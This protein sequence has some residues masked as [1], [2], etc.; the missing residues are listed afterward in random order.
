VGH[1][2]LAAEKPWSYDAGVLRRETRPADPEPAERMAAAA[3]V[4]VC[5]LGA[6]AVWVNGE[7]MQLR[8]RE[9][10]VVAALVLHGRGH[11][12]ADRLA[13]LVWT[14]PPPTARKSLQ[15]HI[16]RIRQRVGLELIETTAQ[17]Y[18]LAPW[19]STDVGGL[20]S[21]QGQALG[22][23][24][25]AERA[26]RLEAIL[27]SWRGE[28]Y[29]EL[30]LSD[31]V[32]AARAELH[33]VRAQIEEEL[34]AATLEGGDLQRGVALLK[35]LVVDEPFRERR[36]WLYMVGLYRADQRRD[37]LLA[38]SD[39]QA[40]LAERVGLDAGHELRVLEARIL[41][42]DPR[43]DDLPLGAGGTALRGAFVG[44]AA[45]QL[46]HR[47]VGRSEDLRQ[48]DAV[49]SD[50]V[51]SGGLRM[52]V[53]EADAGEG[54]TRLALEVARTIHERGG[55]I[56]WGRCSAD[57]GLP[58][59][60]VVEALG[61]VVDAD[62]GLLDRLGPQTEALAAILPEVRRH[63][64]IPLLSTGPGSDARS[65]LFRA[66]GAAF[67]DLTQAPLLW[68]VDDLQ[69]AAGDTLALLDHTFRA[70]SERPVL[71]LVTT[72]QAVGPIAGA[73]GRWQR[74]L[75]ATTIRL[76]GLGVADVAELLG[77]RASPASESADAIG[78][79]ATAMA[80]H[81]RT[82]GNAFYVVSLLSA[83]ELDGD[84]FFDPDQVPET[85]RSWIRRRRD[86]LPASVAELLGLGAVVGIE[87]DIDAQLLADC[88][89]AGM[90]D[91]IDGYERLLREGFFEEPAASVLRFP[92]ALVRDAVY[93]SLSGFRRAWF[94]RRV[95][96]ALEARG[97][98]SPV[99][100]AYH[101]SR[102]GPASDAA[103]YRHAMAATELALDQG[104][105]ASASEHGQLTRARAQAPG[106]QARALVGV[107]R[108]QRAQGLVVEAR[109]S[110]QTAIDLAAA[111]GVARPFAEGVLAL[112][113][114]GGGGRGVAVELDDVERIDLLRRA[115]AGLDDADADL[116]VAVLSE[117]AW[118]LLLTDRAGER[119]ALAERAIEVARRTTGTSHLAAALNSR[120]LVR[121]GPT[122]LALRLADI[123]EILRL[124]ETARPTEA[125]LAALVARH[126]DLLTLGDRTGAREALSA[127][128]DLAEAYGHP[129]WSWVV[130]SWRALDAVID[131]NLER[132]EALAFAALEWQ[133]DFPRAQACL[134]VNLVDLRLYQ[135][136]AVEV[137]D[138]LE[139]AVRE[140]PHIPTYRA[141]LTLC[142]WESGDIERATAEYRWFADENFTNIPDD[143]N[144]LLAL[145]VLGSVAARLGT[146]EQ[147][148]ALSELLSPWADQHVVLNCYDGGGAYWGP[149]AH[150]LA[151]LSPVG[152]ERDRLFEQAEVA[153]REFGAPLAV[154]RI[155]EDRRTI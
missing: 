135:G 71:V 110:L 5:V 19:V 64:T 12:D 72:R 92:H 91:F 119:V 113:G 114:G 38:F 75:R 58:Y 15:N 25:A 54:K 89:G 93:D 28:A 56:V 145:G 83:G 73:L 107:G 138:L 144:R 77:D 34:A 70:V 97:S 16:V 120:R 103:T 22:V 29:V 14:D 41:N 21:A 134:G 80:L 27:E 136:R 102:A 100:L 47:F 148:R 153:A 123:D 46:E 154:Q 57:A 6:C 149:V 90:G 69:W 111:E 13:E 131:G 84:G 59:E 98:E 68:V 140:N 116:L 45:D 32:D 94:H 95:A 127:C 124:P 63:A 125:T 118:S 133:P 39:A 76:R 122:N 11:L 86:E 147:R 99:L 106:E 151:V 4:R 78:T 53:V 37:S 87:V 10:G 129:F 143:T 3:E 104:A 108:A 137:V 121:S 24:G 23:L 152:T 40:A 52:V 126:E 155:L 60:P 9:R 51:A 8:P 30:P 117:L 20:A 44:P 112:V 150:I 36:W 139:A 65:L 67:S 17:G 115:L 49:W 33:E 101:F 7:A 74:W 50:V 142:C 82:G 43:L 146:T 1:G 2:A 88:S 132:A 130:T 109:V 81:A 85:L 66:V 96:D 141:V 105:W 35:R 48:I 62:R 79:E 55:T 31:P 18:R 128:V 26:R 42:E 61:R